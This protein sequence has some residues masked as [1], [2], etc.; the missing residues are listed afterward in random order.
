[1]LRKQLTAAAAVPEGQAVKF[2]F[3]RN[4]K[5]VHGFLARYQGQLFAYENR[6]RHLPLSL[7]YGDGRFFSRDGTHFICQTHGALY[8]PVSGLCIRGPCQ[9]EKLKPLPIEVEDGFVWLNL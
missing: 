3:V 5:S 1:M 2:Q 7:D 6:C 4:G 8:D 9:G